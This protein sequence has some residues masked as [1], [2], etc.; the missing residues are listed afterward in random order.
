MN[1]IRQLLVPVLGKSLGLVNWLPHAGNLILLI[2]SSQTA[3]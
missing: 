3:R 1:K 2:K